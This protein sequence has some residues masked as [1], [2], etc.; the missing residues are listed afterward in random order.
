MG[1]TLQS[2]LSGFDPNQPSTLAS[3]APVA[4]AT[5]SPSQPSTDTFNGFDPT[6]PSTLASHA[7]TPTTAP[8]TPQPTTLQ[9]AVQESPFGRIMDFATQSYDNAAKQRDKEKS[10]DQEVA[11]HLKN[12]DYGRAA[13]VL[14][15]HLADNYSSAMGTGLGIAG[16]DLAQSIWEPSS[17]THEPQAYAAEKLINDKFGP[18]L[19]PNINAVMGPFGRFDVAQGA[20]GAVIGAKDVAPEE[21]PNLAQK[22]WKGR[23]VE[24]VPAQAALRTA[25]ADSAP[26]AAEPAVGLPKGSPS[27]FRAAASDAGEAAGTAP[28]TGGIRTLQSQNIADIAKLERATYDT[29]NKAAGT[30]LKS[31]YDYREEVQDALDDPTN[32]ASRTKL[33]EELDTTNTSIQN[34]EAQAIHNKVNPS[35]LKDAVKLTQKRYALEAVD[36][37]IYNSNS[38][39]KGNVA[40]GVD[41]TINVDGAI[42]QLENLDKPSKFAPR[43]S[44][45]RLQQA[46]GVDGAAKLKQSFYD[47]QKLGRSAVTARWVAT[48]LA[49]IAVTGGGAVGAKKAAALI[50]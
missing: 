40:H 13:K 10:V 48:I 23:D 6:A 19:G 35:T 47:A 34:G 15:G 31:L 11:G 20:V 41:E 1:G 2:P 50:P 9:S 25:A 16:G 43:G 29:L 5:P 17:P 4:G 7:S 44:P 3:H 8:T 22:L 28:A 42:T 24:Q 18:T 36:N 45:T 12:H 14:L 21:G 49:G 37:K 32:I 46:Y 27:P 38:L 33:Q 39:V 26:A 30:D